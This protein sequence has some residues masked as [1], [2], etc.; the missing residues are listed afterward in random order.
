MQVKVELEVPTSVT[1]FVTTLCV[2]RLANTCLFARV[3]TVNQLWH[4]ERDKTD[5]YSERR[6]TN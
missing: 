6:V 2:Y 1:T 5:G 3:I 4:S